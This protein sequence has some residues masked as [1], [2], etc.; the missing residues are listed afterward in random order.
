[1]AEELDRTQQVFI[2]TYT[3]DGP[4]FSFIAAMSMPEKK[5]ILSGS[6]S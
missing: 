3:L 1:M 5:N 2:C 4:R 6:V